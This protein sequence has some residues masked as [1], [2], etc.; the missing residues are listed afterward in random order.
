MKDGMNSAQRYWLNHFI[1]PHRQLAICLFVHGKLS[2]G[3]TD[4]S[5]DFE[6]DG[7]NDNTGELLPVE[8]EGDPR[9]AK[10]LALAAGCILASL[11]VPLVIPG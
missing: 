6:S 10:M 5:S 8:V 1:D 4:G 7:Q 11:L 2:E 3:E 9:P